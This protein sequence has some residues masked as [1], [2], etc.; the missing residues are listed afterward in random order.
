MHV[1]RLDPAARI[2]QSR[3]HNASV[4]QWDHTLSVQPDKGGTIWTDTILIDAPRG[5][6]ATA[7]F[8]RFVYKRRH[9]HRRAL[10]ITTHINKV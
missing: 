4:S 1:E 5:A 7:R 8:A 2:I 9:K 10:A 6:W 3:E